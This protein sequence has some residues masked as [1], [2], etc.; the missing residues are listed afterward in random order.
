[1]EPTSAFSA[2]TT[3]TTQA[4]GRCSM[5]VHLGIRIEGGECDRRRMRG[6]RPA[7][8]EGTAFEHF[9]NLEKQ[10][11]VVS[12]TPIRNMGTVAGNFVT[13]PIGHLTVFLALDMGLSCRL[14][15]S[16]PL[17]WRA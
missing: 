7:C 16:P 13:P 6:E 8:I 17:C 15:W 1:M 10:L 2:T 4:S 12:S 3:C 14:L 9:A 11:A 5:M